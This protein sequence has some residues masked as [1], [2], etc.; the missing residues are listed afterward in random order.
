MHWEQHNHDRHPWHP[1]RQWSKKRHHLRNGALSVRVKTKA[2]NRQEEGAS[3]EL[4]TKSAFKKN[5]LY[6]TLL[7]QADM[8][9]LMKK[10]DIQNTKARCHPTGNNFENRPW[11]ETRSKNFEVSTK[12]KWVSPWLSSKT[13]QQL[14]MR[15][16]RSRVDAWEG[17]LYCFQ[18]TDLHVQVTQSPFCHA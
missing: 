11:W 12:A 4:W 2:T 9:R 14:K 5:D 10:H 18:T 13:D 7:T 1:D 6:R 3:M 16:T 17:F 8:A 15:T